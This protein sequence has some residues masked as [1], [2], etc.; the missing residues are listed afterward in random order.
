MKAHRVVA[1]AVAILLRRVRA[2][3][4][5]TWHLWRTLTIERTARARRVRGRARLVF[6]MMMRERRSVLSKCLG[7]WRLNAAAVLAVE[8]A[9]EDARALHVER[10]ANDLRRAAKMLGGVSRVML[11]NAMQKWR[12][13]HSEPRRNA[14]RSMFILLRVTELTAAPRQTPLQVCH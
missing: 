14:P 4:E 3:C 7:R 1:R 11:A 5:R 10:R 6:R 8:L 12:C 2:R 9:D 13:A